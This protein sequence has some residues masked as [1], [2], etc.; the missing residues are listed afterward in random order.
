MSNTKYRFQLFI[1]TNPRKYQ[2]GGP[3]DLL[4]VPIH[5]FEVEGGANRKIETGA[6][7]AISI[8][9]EMEQARSFK[10]I[11]FYVLPTNNFLGVKL[12][13][14]RSPHIRF[15]DLTFEVGVYSGKVLTQNLFMHC[16][17]AWFVRVPTPMGGTPPLLQASV[18]FHSDSVKLRHGKYDAKKKVL[19]WV[20][21]SVLTM[22]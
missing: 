3:T 17:R 19:V 5:A 15:F 1:M 10:N 14:Q 12:V 9:S 2:D 18:H 20:F 7:N 21:L 8:A 22:E 13:G 6:P 11:T 16:A 4:D